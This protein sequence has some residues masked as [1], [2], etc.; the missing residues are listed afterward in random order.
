MLAGWKNL[1]S[2][3]LEREGKFGAHSGRKTGYLFGVWGGGQ[4]TDLMLSA[5]PKTLKNTLRHQASAGISFRPINELAGIFVHN[6]LGVL[7]DKHCLTL[8]KLLGKTSRVTVMNMA[9]WTKQ[10]RSYRPGHWKQD[11]QINWQNSRATTF[12]IKT[13]NATGK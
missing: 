9:T 12:T 6:K 4:D 5:R 2:T 13:K 3:V 1:C 7:R 10:G 8:Q 11:F